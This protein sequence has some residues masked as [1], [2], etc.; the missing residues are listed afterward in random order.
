MISS[1]HLIEEEGRFVRL[2]A[3]ALV[4]VVTLPTYCS[5]VLIAGLRAAIV[6]AVACC[7]YTWLHF[8]FK[9]SLRCTW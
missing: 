8:S 9:P 4:F 2:V 6:I 7:M 5:P 1:T 3:Y